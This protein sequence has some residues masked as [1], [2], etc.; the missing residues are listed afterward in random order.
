MIQQSSEN[1]ERNLQLRQI[2]HDTMLDPTLWQRGATQS[3]GIR[4][5]AY[6]E[7]LPISMGK[8]VAHLQQ[9]G[10]TSTFWSE[11]IRLFVLRGMVCSVTIAPASTGSPVEPGQIVT[12]AMASQLAQERTEQP[13]DG[14]VVSTP[15][16]AWSASRV[17][18]LLV[19]PAPTRAVSPSI[20][21]DLVTNDEDMPMDTS[22]VTTSLTTTAGSENTANISS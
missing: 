4:P 5:I 2:L 8:M 21:T 18:T 19:P 7:E 10:V 15:L 14:S 6:L 9:Y 11:Q 3:M 22:E 1:A 20:V 16:V 12:P 13:S 17:C